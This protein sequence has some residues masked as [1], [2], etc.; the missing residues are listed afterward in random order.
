MLWLLP[1]KTG[2]RFSWSFLH[3][4]LPCADLS[5]LAWVIVTWI[6]FAVD[7]VHSFFITDYTTS[8]IESG[9]SAPAGRRAIRPAP[10]H[11]AADALTADPT[12]S[13]H[14]LQAGP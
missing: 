1:V 11:P 12:V 14:A 6:S 5:T 7:V 4:W 10:P 2:N 3:N 13:S 9:I 8:F